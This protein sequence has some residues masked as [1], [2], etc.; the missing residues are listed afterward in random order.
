MSTSIINSSPQIDVPPS[1]ENGTKPSTEQ[2]GN[3][4]GRTITTNT[5]VDAST[6]DDECMSSFQAEKKAVKEKKEDD[7]KKLS[8]NNIQKPK[9]TQKTQE[10]DQRSKRISNNTEL[11]L[12]LINKNSLNDLKNTIQERSNALFFG[13]E[14][15]YQKCFETLEGAINKKSCNSETIKNA[16]SAF[17]DVAEQHNALE[18]ARSVL[19]LKLPKLKEL[20]EKLRDNSE[21]LRDEGKDSEDAK[22]DYNRLQEQIKNLEESLDNIEKAQ[23][24]LMVSNGNRIDDS[25]KL[26]SLLRK[27]TAHFTHDITLPP[28]DF[29]ALLLDEI[30]PLKGDMIQIFDCLTKGFI[31]NLSK[32]EQ[33]PGNAINH[34][35]DNI[36]IVIIGLN[37]ELKSC[38][39]PKISS[40]IINSCRSTEKLGTVQELNTQMLQKTYATFQI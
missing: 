18:I 38:S 35:K 26:A 19:E 13:S 14:E 34:F 37:Q 30:L 33:S 10:R 27:T 24:A 31:E 22:N 5:E 32:N 25:Y 4:E 12:I 17:D 29:N 36:S 21:K 23:N 40:A 39:D 8:L 15:K 16:L 3:L 20:S 28:K 7:K 11:W 6:K 2:V 9:E 1:S